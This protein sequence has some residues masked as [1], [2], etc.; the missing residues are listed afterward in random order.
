M[1][2]SLTSLEV[3]L[4]D[5]RTQLTAWS[6]DGS[7]RSA[8]RTALRLPDGADPAALT[9][10][11]AAWAAGDFA[12]LPPIE[13]LDGSVLP[14]AAGAYALSTGTIYLNG[15][16]LASASEQ[17]VIAVLTE[18][19]G[20]HL[21]GLLNA[22]DTPG[23]EGELFAALIVEKEDSSIACIRTISDNDHA[24]LQ[25]IDGRIVEIEQSVPSDFGVN[26]NT[27]NYTSNRFSGTTA[28]YG[29]QCTTY[30]YGRALEKGLYSANFS[31][32]NALNNTYPA[33]GGLWDDITGVQSKTPVAN[34]FIVWDPFTGGTNAEGH[35]GFVE[36]VLA[37]GTLVVTEANYPSGSTWRSINISPGTSRYTSAKF[38][39]LDGGSATPPLTT[40]EGTDDRL[41]LPI[42]DPA[43]YLAANADVRNAY[44][45]SNI[46]G[47]KSHWL[48]FGIAEGRQGS[49]VFNPKYYLQQFQ[50]VANAYGATNYAGAISHWLE[51]GLNFGR[52]GSVEFDPIYYM[53][54]H[55]DV[56]QAYGVMNFSGAISHYYQWGKPGGW[57]GSEWITDSTAF[58]LGYYL[59]NNADVKAVTNNAN[60]EVEATRHWY[61]NGINEG[62]RGSP[63]F[64][65]KFYLAKYEDVRAA[66]GDNNYRGALDN[67]LLF[68]KAGGRI[69][70]DDTPRTLSINDVG[71]IE[72][73]S[74]SQ[75]LVFTVSL[76]IVFGDPVA[77]SY[78]TANGTATDGSDYRAISGSLSFA[79]GE[80]SKSISI[81][82]F[83]DNTFE[84]DETFTVNLSGSS[85]A[86]IV[87]GQGVGTIG[88]DDPQIV[89]E[90]KATFSLAGTPTVGQILTASKTSDD[91]DGNGSFSYL[92]QSSADGNSWV[93]IG[94]NSPTQLL[95]FAEAGKQVRVNISYIDGDGFAEVVSAPPL[96]VGRG[97]VLAAIAGITDNTGLIQGAIAPA[98]RTDDRTPTIT[99]TFSAP[100]VAGESVRIFNGTSL[101]GNAVVNNTTGTWSYTPTLPITPGTSYSITARVADAAGN[102]GP[103]STARRFTLDATAP[104]TTAAITS[105]SDNAGLLQGTVAPS[106]R[107]DDL[108]PTITGTVSVALVS[109]ETL[110]IFN[111]AVLLGN[112]T[113]NNSAKTWSYT[114]TLPAT[115]GTSYSITARVADAAGNLGVASTARRF[116]LDTTAPLTTA[117]ITSVS[118]NAGLLQGTVAPGG[119]TDDLTPTI[120]G[121]VSVALVSGETLRLFHGSTLLGNATVNN[122]AKT[123]SY[124]PPCP[125]HPAPV[126]RSPRASPMPRAILAPLLPHAASRS[127][128]PRPRLF[129]LRPS[130]GPSVSSQP[131]T[132][133]SPSQKTS[134]AER[135]PFSC[136]SDRP[137]DRSPKVLMP[138]RA[139]GSA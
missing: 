138:P 44:G 38:I 35:V 108:A 3:L 17:Q 6:I 28:Q 94:S 136:V 10:L 8:A 78:S 62:R 128:P 95:G 65:P 121:T 56:E 27:P 131:P 83:G 130:M 7:L 119:R 132:F 33:H 139:L 137:L 49:L 79:P 55:P 114:P 4:Q 31:I 34:S 13:V 97:A 25:L 70:A 32:F 60:Q 41:K 64:D 1:A 90:G 53:A 29:F 19:L 30:A 124:T 123:W 2:V 117:A 46:E 11:I 105:V 71:I 84:S 16:W 48:Q 103:A 127:I 98:G 69:G 66:Y 133:A 75:F 118:D 80:T 92:W 85:N 12:G 81:E 125:S 82:I 122:S 67:Y 100:L 88:N 9:G 110:R 135:A 39:R 15:A 116:T 112:A 111:G 63:E 51:W 23:D 120:T 57:Y 5:W 68:G 93:N 18:E 77:V 99:G 87:K 42:F 58:Q 101:L 113:V 86:S 22:S 107:T 37:D 52:R 20:H 89:N 73:S 24:L 40:P 129:R 74:G 26:L 59:A 126:I 76:N 96:L 106:G 91:P 47:A 54:A 43:Y 72:G 61:F 50:D 115:T 109:G 45:S 134:S 102:P 14:G 36:Q 104:L 21:D